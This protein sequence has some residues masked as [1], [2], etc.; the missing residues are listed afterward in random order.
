MNTIKVSIFKYSFLLL[1]FISVIGISDSF[2]QLDE[3]AGI[4]SRFYYSGILG[5]SEKIEF[6]MQINGYSVTGSYMSVS[7]GDIFLFKGRLAAD[8]SAMGVLVYDEQNNYL[9]SVEA[10]VISQELDFASEI[11]GVWKSLKG[12]GKKNISLD[13]V[14]EFARVEAPKEHSYFE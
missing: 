8:K 3:P 1:L 12:G 6:N 14:A 5:P 2:G 7:T 11:K 4:N 10:E 9:A 13:K